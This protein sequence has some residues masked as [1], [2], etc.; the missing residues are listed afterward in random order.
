MSAPALLA[1]SKAESVYGVT[2]AIA[3]ARFDRV[4][5]RAAT[6][7]KSAQ[8]VNL[9]PFDPAQFH[10][11]ISA[12]APDMLRIA[13]P[14]PSRWAMCKLAGKYLGTSPDTILRICEGNT[15]RN[16]VALLCAAVPFYTARAGK[17]PPMAEMLIQLMQG[18][19]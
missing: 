2:S 14:A 5:N 13:F 4:S 1:Q 9:R 17:M 12:Q 10:A 11:R 6:L 18:G 7:R 15:H 3:L 8:I 19:K 16:D